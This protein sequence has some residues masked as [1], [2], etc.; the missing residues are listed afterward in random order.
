MIACV[1]SPE[2]GVY[3]VLKRKKGGTEDTLRKF[4]KRVNDS[5]K[6]HLV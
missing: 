5:L 4:M 2:D 3:E 6:I 1:I